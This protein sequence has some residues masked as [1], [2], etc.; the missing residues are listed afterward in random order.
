M[1]V[2]AKIISKTAEF[3]FYVIRD[4]TNKSMV[5]EKLITISRRVTIIFIVLIVVAVSAFISI[6]QFYGCSDYVK[7]E[8]KSYQEASEAIE[9][10][11]IPNNILPPTSSKIVIWVNADLNNLH[12]YCDLGIDYNEY[13]N[14]IG[15]NHKF[16]PE[17]NQDS[18]LEYK[19][20]DGFIVKFDWEK[21]KMYWSR[22][23]R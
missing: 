14:Y 2:V 20:Y 4:Q 12:G 5:I 1:T 9:N 3:T 22:G 10:N 13:T 15:N 23:V 18:S 19:T 16:T 8:I 17:I 6:T 11:L 21:R 7:I